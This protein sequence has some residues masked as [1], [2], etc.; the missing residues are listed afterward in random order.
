MSIDRSLLTDLLLDTLEPTTTVDGP[1]GPVSEIREWV[2][3]DHEKPPAGGWQGEP[4]HSEWVPYFI[5]SSSPSSQISGDLATPE[6]DV[7]FGYAVTVV[8]R[9]R[10][11]VEKASMVARERLRSLNR[12][13]TS[14][15]RTISKVV[16]SSYGGATR[17]PI[18]PVI[19]LNSDQFR[20]YTTK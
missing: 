8:T 6:S 15:D 19:F 12:Q 17:I 2:V 5:L 4:G 14:D 13:K 7:W 18:E 16:I 11:G 9:T 3:G 10:R 20:I 1:S